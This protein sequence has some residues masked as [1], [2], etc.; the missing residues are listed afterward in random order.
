VEKERATR[1]QKVNT[2]LQVAEKEY[3]KATQD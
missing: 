1:Q 3:K 2:R